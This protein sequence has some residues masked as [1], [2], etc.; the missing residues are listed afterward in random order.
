[1]IEATAW[2]D[3]LTLVRAA[4]A[5]FAVLYVPGRL[6][7]KGNLEKITHDGLDNIIESVLLSVLFLAIIGIALAFTVGISVTSLLFAY[8]L[9]GVLIWTRH[10]H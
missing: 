5:S 6:F 7:L 8:A 9:S 4:I 1:M 2:P 3:P 10:R